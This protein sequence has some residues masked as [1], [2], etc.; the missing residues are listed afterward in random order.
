LEIARTVVDALEEKKG[1][2]ILL[3]DIHEIAVFADYFVICS[4]TSERMLQ[5]LADAAQEQVKKS[6]GVFGR[7][8]GSSSNG[9]VLV[10]FGDVI[11]HLFSPER[12]NYYHLEELWGKG[13]TLVH[14]Q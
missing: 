9:W 13:K 2:N 3:L 6:H 4:G 8:E 10:D 7:V 1:E 11:L 12:R 14:L 5:A